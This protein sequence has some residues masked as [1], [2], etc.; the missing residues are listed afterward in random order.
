MRPLAGGGAGPAR[1]APGE[2]SRGAGVGP[3][4]GAAGWGA[5]LPPP[6]RPPAPCCACSRHLSPSP[7]VT[8]MTGGKYCVEL[9][10]AGVT[11]VVL[12]PEKGMGVM[13]PAGMMVMVATTG[14][15]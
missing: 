13:V 10:Q 1:G 9:P 7:D 5:A 8:G 15:V 2:Q 6:Q 3:G 14:L 4:A 12:A 11:G